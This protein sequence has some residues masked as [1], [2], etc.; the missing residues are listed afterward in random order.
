VKLSRTIL[1]TRLPTV[2]SI[3]DQYDSTNHDPSS[4]SDPQQEHHSSPLIRGFIHS[5]LER[6]HIHRNRPYTVRGFP[7]LV[8][9]QSSNGNAEAYSRS[10]LLSGNGF[11]VWY[12]GGDLGKSVEYLQKGLSIGDV[13]ILDREG[14]FDFWFN[15]FLPLDDPIHSH[16]VPREFQPIQPPLI[17]SEIAY[18]PDYFKPGD[19]VTSKGVKV[20]VHAKDPL[21]GCLSMVKF[22][23]NIFRF[24]SSGIFHSL[25]PKKRAESLSSLMVL[26][27][28]TSYLL[29]ASTISPEKM[30]H[31]G[32]RSS[33]ATTALFI[34]MALSF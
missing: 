11:P 19:V 2:S 7:K 5:P 6:Q 26:P 18:L 20:T 21:S 15:I 10:L 17:P 34:P 23:T 14:I 8:S 30:P 27:A 1:F 25:R 16:S 29:I 9:V 32:I 33:M 12:P 28:K 4:R 3:D 13:G 22:D 24:F 31:I